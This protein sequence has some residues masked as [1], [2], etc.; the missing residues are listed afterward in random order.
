MCP[1]ER[2]RQYNT[3]DP[4]GVELEKRYDAIW[5]V[6]AHDARELALHESKVHSRFASARTRRDTGNFTEWFRV[7]CAEVAAFV[8]G[9]AFAVRQLTVD[10][11][12]AVT[13]EARST[14]A[15]EAAEADR[16]E[17]V[18]AAE[19]GEA[20]RREEVEAVETVEADRREEG[21]RRQ[22]G[23]RREEGEALALAGLTSAEFFDHVLDKHPPRAIQ[24]ELWSACEAHTA[25]GMMSGIVQWPTGSGKTVAMLTIVATCASRCAALGLVFRGLIVAPKN[26]IFD[27]L[28]G[29]IRKLERW[30][31]VVCEGHNARLVGASVP[32]DVPVLVTATHAMLT[33]R[34]TWLALP[35]MTLVHYDE[36]HRATGDEFFA[37]LTEMRATWGTAYVTG[38]SATPMTCCR[39]QHEKLDRIFGSTYIHRCDID[40]AIEERWIAR[41]R[42]TVHVTSRSSRSDTVAQFVDLVFAA[43]DAKRQSGAWRTGKVIAYLPRV[44]ETREAEAL[45]RRRG[46]FSVFAALDG[47]RATDFLGAAGDAVLFACERFRE[48]SDVRYVEIVAVLAGEEI[49]ANVLLQIAGRALR[50]D[51]PDKEGWCVVVKPTD[52]EPDEV[53]DEIVTSIAEYLGMGHGGAGARLAAT[54]AFFGELTVN[55][56]AYDVAE[57]IQ[58]IQ[59]LHAA[60]GTGTTIADYN[61]HRARNAALGLRCRAEYVGPRDAEDRFSRHWVSWYHFLGVD[62]SMFPVTKS[63]WVEECRSRGIRSWGEYQRAAEA[64]GSGLPAEPAEMYDTYT[65]W[66][67]ELGTEAPL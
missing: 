14:E 51:Y 61:A 20:D 23:D 63:A 30:G 66:D 32:R 31:I 29:H 38:T 8:I 15:V 48:G 57:T 25:R 19:A 58:R 35:P 34:S 62:V 56:R 46:T 22:D 1:V 17:E 54:R 52:S 60:L 65:N 6:R 4:P 26:D 33:K 39:R 50:A 24:A 42:F 27:T 41:P 67:E 9:Q 44:A 49:G 21:D 28:V 47:T 10:E 43:V 45:A 40:T 2:M 16:R 7:D 3:G 36:A 53:F 13:R 12:D 5:E 18:E 64:P 37:L 11:V 55:G 59:T